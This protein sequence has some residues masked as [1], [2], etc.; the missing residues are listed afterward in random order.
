MKPP[1][2]PDDAAK[3]QRARVLYVTLLCTSV[4]ISINQ[5][6]TVTG[7]K[8]PVQNAWIGMLL[9]GFCIIGYI[10]MHFGLIKTVGIGLLCATYFVVTLAIINI[11]TIRTPITMVYYTIIIIG[12]LLFDL[13][14]M[15]I[16]MIISSTTVGGLILAQ[17]AGLL[18]APDYSV[19]I[20]QWATLVGLFITNGGLIAV[21]VYWTR[22]ALHRAETENAERERVTKELL[23]NQEKLKQ[24]NTEL[25]H[26]LSEVKTLS[27]LLPICA[28][29]KKIRDDRGYWNRIES[30]ISHHTN[31]DFTHGICPDC[32]RELY[33]AIDQL[34]LEL[35]AA[36]K[37]SI[38]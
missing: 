13:P 24:I 16:T 8:V 34:S 4:Y 27:G 1:V 37:K 15:V 10:G 31:A 2:F 21:V 22:Q 26:V 28:N 29:C 35:E 36:K 18:P 33:P 25:Q 14:G 17:N 19:T 11:G 20:V 32:M 9:F 23:E 38:K 5:L 30:Y 7:G 6:V 3:T 12:G